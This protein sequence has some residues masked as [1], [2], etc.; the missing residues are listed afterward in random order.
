MAADENRQPGSPTAGEQQEWDDA[1]AQFNQLL[2]E[3]QRLASVLEL[4]QMKQQPLALLGWSGCPCTNIARQRFESAGACYVQT[5][6]PTDTAPRLSWTRNNTPSTP[7]NRGH[8]NLSA[9]FLKDAGDAGRRVYVESGRGIYK[10][11]R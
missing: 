11:S 5:V 1:E 9:K 3:R 2:E 6:W 4:E 7:S 10:D 8:G